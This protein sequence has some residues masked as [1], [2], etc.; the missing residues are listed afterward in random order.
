MHVLNS[1]EQNDYLVLDKYEYKG[2]QILAK[3]HHASNYVNYHDYVTYQANSLNSNVL[4]QASRIEIIIP[5][6]SSDVL[7][8]SPWLVIKCSE[9]VGTATVTPCCVPFFFDRVE[10]ST[11]GR[12][13]QTLYPEE[14]YY[15]NLQL[16]ADERDLVENYLNVTPASIAANGKQTYMMKLKFWNEG[17][18]LYLHALDNPIN[19]IFYTKNAVSAGTGT[20][21]VSEMSLIFKHKHLFAE[22]KNEYDL[23]YNRYAV[24]RQHL[25]CVKLVNN[26]TLTAG[27]KSK[28]SLRQLGNHKVAY[29]LLQVTSSNSNT[30][31]GLATFVDL[32]GTDKSGQLEVLSPLNNVL[33]RNGY[34][35][36]ADF[37]RN[38]QALNNEIQGTQYFNDNNSYVISFCDDIEMAHGGHQNGL[39]YI[40]SGEEYNLQI[41][42]PTG[43]TSAV[44]YV[45][46]LCFV[47]KKLFI[48][49]GTLASQ[50]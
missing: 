16:R 33:L 35:P 24:M 1:F 8:G 15:L 4:V 47:Y 23:N 18:E 25:E 38:I 19:I 12:I 17:D 20:L 34:N 37:Y 21:S 3:P 50:N 13:L 27:V 40:N 14:L 30:S 2:K 7:Q 36:S 41:L 45:N 10:I 22:D 26:V 49:D 44:Y 11:S 48:S 29:I 6:K 32:I 46:M 5:A 39:L 43:I 28:L 31:N 9:S 42:P